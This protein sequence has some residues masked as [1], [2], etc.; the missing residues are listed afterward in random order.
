MSNIPKSHECYVAH[1]DGFVLKNQVKESLEVFEKAIKKFNKTKQLVDHPG[2][3]I[4]FKFCP[5]CGESV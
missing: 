4:P 3:W 1:W 5:I 2:V